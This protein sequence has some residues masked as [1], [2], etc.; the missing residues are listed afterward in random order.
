MNFVPRTSL[1]CVLESHVGV[2]KEI[3]YERKYK[4][5]KKEDQ[6]LFI[7]TVSELNLVYSHPST[8]L[9]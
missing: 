8:L 4:E 9:D 1:R 6:I 2:N 3:D 5:M 7:C